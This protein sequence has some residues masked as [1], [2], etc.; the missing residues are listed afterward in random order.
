MVLVES[1]AIYLVN[2]KM[3]IYWCGS[4]SKSRSETLLD[5]EL[6]QNLRTATDKKDGGISLVVFDALYVDGTNVRHRSIVERMRVAREFLKWNPQMPFGLIF[7][8]YSP[9]SQTAKVLE[10]AATQPHKTD[11]VV[12]IYG[13]SFVIIYIYF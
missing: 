9:V 4:T 7:K 12:C 6:V 3:E 11:G 2:R 8:S 10:E 13:V 5:C 1:G